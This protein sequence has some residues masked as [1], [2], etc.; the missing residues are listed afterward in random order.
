MGNTTNP[1]KWEARQRLTF[2]EEAAFWRGWVRRADLEREFGISLPQASADLQAYLSRFPKNLRYDT[3]SKRYC[4]EEAMRAELAQPDLARA[5]CRFLGAESKRADRVDQVA[6]IDMPQRSLNPEVIRHVFR[7]VHD[8]L[9]VR[10]FYH[11]IHS[12]T[13]TWRWITPHAFAHDGYRWHT[14]AFSHEDQ[15]YKDF[16]LGR[17]TAADIPVEKPR[18][19]LADNEWNTWEKVRLRPHRRLDPVQR[20]AI[21]FD[22][23]MRNGSV[24]LDVRRSML[25]YTLSYLRVGGKPLPRQLELAG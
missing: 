24:V 19:R 5:I 21:E 22:Y 16:V 3:K 2:L 14:R 7:A 20:K 13:A 8:G 15:S 10:I 6:S 17:T 25:N 1:D 12:A 18:P 9:A 23:D 4:A 11:S